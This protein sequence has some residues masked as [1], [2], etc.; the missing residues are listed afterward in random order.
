MII[1]IT[2]SLEWPQPR[3]FRWITA[4]AYGAP[5]HVDHREFPVLV[6]DDAQSNEQLQNLS[7]YEPFVTQTSL[8]LEISAIPPNPDGV[9][10]FVR[11]FGPLSIDRFWIPQG[12]DFEEMKLTMP[13]HPRGSPED[14]FVDHLA[15]DLIRA[16]HWRRGAAVIG[17]SLDH[18]KNLIEY[19]SRLVWAWQTMR[20]RKLEDCVIVRKHRDV[21]IVDLR[22]RERRLLQSTKLAA[23]PKAAALPQVAKSLLML[24][25][26]ERL[27]TRLPLGVVARND[28]V[29]A[30]L[31]ALPQSLEDAIWL[32]F[33]LAVYGEKS[34]RTCKVC[35]NRFE[36][37]LEQHRTNRLLCSNSCKAA[38]HRQRRKL[39]LKLAA[40]GKTPN[41]IA[42]QVGSSLSTVK[43]W[44]SEVSENK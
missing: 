6:P 23:T 34:F 43:K 18:W 1:Q 27:G 30:R 14:Y 12:V 38:A 16:E 41:Q 29:D 3:D 10:D 36:V 21:A 15:H 28:G 19:M 5:S 17:D 8:F 22:D 31:S 37:S 25:I 2:P 20:E 9:L 11:R 33:L 42:K 35:G 26:G 32:Q 24:A 40:D 39:A 44:L 7:S 4:R 13:V